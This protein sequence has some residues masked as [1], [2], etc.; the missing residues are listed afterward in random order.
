MYAISTDALNGLG[1][2]TQAPCLSL[3]QPTHRSQPD[4]A[5]DVVEFRR[6]IQVLSEALKDTDEAHDAKTLLIPFYQLA[7][8]ADF[9]DDTLDGLAVFA[10]PLGFRVFVL[11]QSVAAQTTVASEFHTSPL[12]RFLQSV[13]RYQVLCLSHDQARL[14][15]G[16]RDALEEVVL[17]PEVPANA[18]HAETFE[19]RALD[20]DRFF[21]AL[22]LALLKHHSKPSA[23]PLILAALPEHQHRFRQ[24]S[25]NKRL[26]PV[27]LDVHPGAMN[28]RALSIMAWNVVEPQHNAREQVWIDAFVVARAQGRGSDDV[29]KTALA[30][31]QGRV[32]LL[33]ID[34]DKS[35]SGQFDRRNGH[36]VLSKNPMAHD[37][38]DDIAELVESQGGAV[39]VIPAAHMPT[40]SGLAAAMRV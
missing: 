38:L 25:Q 7:D 6:G 5:Q 36:M 8:D 40:R 4:N 12:R 19:G 24:L 34:S 2:L 11:P 3:Y 20:E 27:G 31:S 16:N 30:A 33:L 28:I 9:W 37:V 26:L 17:G 29:R 22:D 1:V 18:E 39:R 10:S 23:L 21:R 14:F 32:G 35:L 13:D 15:E